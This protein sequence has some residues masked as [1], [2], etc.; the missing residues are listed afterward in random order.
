MMEKMMP[1]MMENYFATMNKKEQEQMFS[2][3]HSMLKDIED[4]YLKQQKK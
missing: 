4:K 3:C 2:F 1:K